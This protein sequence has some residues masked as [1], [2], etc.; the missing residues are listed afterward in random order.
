MRMGKILITGGAG[1][2]GHHMIEYFLKNTDYDIVSLD[3]LDTSGNL[4]RLA[5]VLEDSPEKHRVKIIWHDLKASLNDFVI[6]DIGDVEYIFHL[7]A[8]SHVDRSIVRPMEFVM[9]NV[10][11][12]GN[13][14]EY[15]RHNCPNLKMFLYFSTDEVF[16]PAPEGVHFKDN[17]RYACKNPYSATKAAGEEL[18]LAYENSY[19]MP[20]IATHT[21]NIYGKRQ[22]PEKFIPLIVRK[23]L[24]GEVVE[25]HSNPELTA[26]GKR[27]YLHC[28][29][30]CE[31]MSFLMKNFKPGEKYNIV[32]GEEFSN[33]ELSQMIADILGKELKFE[34]VDPKATRPRFDFRYAC[35]GTKLKDLGWETKTKTKDALRDI[36]DWFQTNDTWLHLKK[37]D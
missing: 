19:H 10:V 12:T 32:A 16:G 11:G 3:R 30:L 28:D 26:A 8:A 14:L 35:D 31:A 2:V 15:A 6:S 5:E 13:I 21:M 24:K 4:N 29:D 7:A 1:F 25:I 9:D 17:D 33:L 34:M 36:I 37:E 18:A 27:H 22:H 20:I 23:V